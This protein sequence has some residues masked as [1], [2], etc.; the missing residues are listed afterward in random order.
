M[1]AKPH[2]KCTGREGDFLNLSKNEQK[3]R[4]TG[5]LLASSCLVLVLKA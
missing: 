4:L 3:Y 2:E 1:G 5:I